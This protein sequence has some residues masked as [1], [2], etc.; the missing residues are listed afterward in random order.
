MKYRVDDKTDQVVVEILDESKDIIKQIPP[1][2]LLKAAAAVRE[3][4]ALLFD[5][6]A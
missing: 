2:E 1:E 6:S 3:M 4:Q 5:T